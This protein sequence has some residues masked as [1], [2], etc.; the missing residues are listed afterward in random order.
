MNTCIV[1]NYLFLSCTSIVLKLSPQKSSL[2]KNDWK[3]LF[4]ITLLY[5][6]ITNSLFLHTLMLSSPFIFR[7]YDSHP[8]S[9]GFGK[10]YKCLGELLALVKS[11]TPF[12]VFTATATVETKYRIFETPHLNR[13]NTF[14]Y[15]ITPLKGNILYAAHYLNKDTKL[16][17]VFGSLIQEVHDSAVHTPK[18]MIFCQPRT[19]CAL[20]WR[21]FKIKLGVKFYFNETEDVKKRVVEI[22]H[23]VTSI[24]VKKT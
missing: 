18:T 9:S 23:A 14:V 12:A 13:F 7:G 2:M 22:Y 20:L 10:Y 16:E 24:E 6:Y 1:L 11:S 19:Q 15:E 4:N 5:Y 8:N 17:T 21:I 3:C